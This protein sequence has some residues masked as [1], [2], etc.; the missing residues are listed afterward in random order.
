MTGN[1]LIMDKECIA[2]YE[3]HCVIKHAA[4]KIKEAFEGN[5]KLIEWALGQL[6]P[7]RCT[8]EGAVPG[9]SAVVD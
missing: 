7:R 2:Y 8:M 1:F 6:L 5:K 4:G 3:R 9:A